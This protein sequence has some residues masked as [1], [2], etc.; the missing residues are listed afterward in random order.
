MK[1]EKIKKTA[2]ICLAILVAV[3]FIGAVLN[4]VFPE[5]GSFPQRK[6]NVSGQEELN[7]D[8]NEGESIGQLILEKAPV[9]SGGSNVIADVLWDYRGYDTLGEATVLFAAVT[10]VAMLF[11]SLKEEDE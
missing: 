2:G 3:V 7:K 1:K 5:F 6:I 8:I 4:D 10:S 11:R 9:E